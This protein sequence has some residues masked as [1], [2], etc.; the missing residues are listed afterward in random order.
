MLK[1]L[2]VVFW[3]VLFF[4][5]LW[6]IKLIS[7]KRNNTGKCPISEPN[8]RRQFSSFFKRRFRCLIFLYPSSSCCSVFFWNFLYHAL[9]KILFKSYILASYSTWKNENWTSISTT[10]PGVFSST[11]FLDVINYE[12]K[13]KFC[14]RF[15]KIFCVMFFFFWLTRKFDILIFSFKTDMCSMKLS[16][17]RTFSNLVFNNCFTFN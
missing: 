2:P 14:V 6:F 7:S 10:V 16:N 3:V 1:K 4:G 9:F 15:L 13:W 8:G 12:S 11:V 5:F 17:S